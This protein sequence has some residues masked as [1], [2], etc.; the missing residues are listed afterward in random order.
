M[1][2]RQIGAMPFLAAMLISNRLEHEEQ[3][4]VN[5]FALFAYIH[6][7]KCNFIQH[8]FWNLKF[9]EMFMSWYCI[10]LL[11]SSHRCP[12][13]IIQW[14]GA[15]PPWYN[16]TLS[17]LVLFI[18][19]W[20]T[21][22]LTIMHFTRKSPR[23]TMLID[24]CHH[25]QTRLKKGYTFSSPWYCFLR[26]VYNDLWYTE[27]LFHSRWYCI[28]SSLSFSLCFKMLL[29]YIRMSP[30]KWSI[31]RLSWM[32][33]SKIILK[34][35]WLIDRLIDLDHA[36]DSRHCPIVKYYCIQDLYRQWFKKWCH[37]CSV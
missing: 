10:S 18:Y 21:T 24:I 19:R 27:G 23:L 20:V 6:H 1:A 35:H 2:W 32:I 13:C 17:Y 4:S 28:Y 16:K 33:K 11:H 37:T 12:C 3:L 5:Y 14:K 29:T 26:N 7:Q 9:L 8:I 36:L 31:I 34:T 22:D 25:I 15:F 30:R